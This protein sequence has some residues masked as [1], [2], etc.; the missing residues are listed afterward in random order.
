[1]IALGKT[2]DSKAA[3]AGKRRGQRH[4]LLIV[5]LSAVALTLSASTA[6][7]GPAILS[8][9]G[10]ISQRLVPPQA[11]RFALPLRS[12]ESAE[13][14]VDQKGVDVAV[15]VLDPR[16]RLLDTIDSPNG[17]NGPEPVF[18]VARTTG[19]YVVVVRPLDGEPPGD[20]TIDFQTHRNRAATAQLLRERQAVRSQAV[21]WLGPRSSP[22]RLAALRQPVPL[23]PLDAV[24]AQARVIGL[25]E[26]THGSR[27]F[28][29]VRLAIVKRLIEQHGYRVVALEDSAVRWRDLASYVSGAAAAPPSGLPLEWGWIGRRSRHELLGWVRQWN[30][31]HPNDKVAV[32]GVDAQD[33][34]RARQRFTSFIADAYGA[35]AAKRW[36]DV[37]AELAAA[38][39]Q[40]EVFGDSGVSSGSRQAV[41]EVAALLE[42]DRPLL[43]ARLGAERTEQAL[44][45]I[46]DLAQFVDFNGAGAAITSHSRDWYMAINVLSALGEDR[47]RK[48]I[49]WGHNSHVSA[50][51][52]RWGPTGA[53]LR[54]ALGC[55][56]EALAI[57][58]GR[59][60][61]AAQ[62]PNDLQDRVV[63][64]TVDGPQE[65]S[66]ENVLAATG[67]GPRLIWWGCGTAE[68]DPPAWLRELRP[69]RWVGGLYAPD[70][71]P[72]GSYQ[73]YRLTRSFDGIIYFPS[74]AAEE[75]G[76]ARPLIPARQRPS[77]S[78]Q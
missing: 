61:F 75:P 74:V 41:L 14:V 24:A 32:V 1:M 66:I 18:V 2:L 64:S 68:T 28:N 49:Y 71:A 57:T 63:V 17:R 26:A 22:L 15:D 27:E 59:G 45:D 76:P 38:D 10:P 62:I 65:E 35:D 30:L 50:A 13:L 40:T 29:D 23:A 53:L 34:A 37:A 48:G 60:S 69:M 6:A 51:S 36:R 52:T 5:S 33:N 16:G 43:Q 46:R 8:P 20:I 78:P 67:S 77:D 47:Q 70:T 55:G 44:A 4:R 3:V 31:S 39:E 54:E 21:A 12:G 11:H 7:Q 73:P 42:Q 72:T 19:N 58:F 56:Y 25:G 9:G